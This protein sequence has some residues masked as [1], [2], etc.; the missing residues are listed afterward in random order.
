M[1]QTTA[2]CCSPAVVAETGP[3]LRETQSLCRAPNG[4]SYIV[5]KSPHQKTDE[6]FFLLSKRFYFA[7]SQSLSCEV[8]SW[9][10][11]FIFPSYLYMTNLNLCFGLNMATKEGVSVC[12]LFSSWLLPPRSVF[13]RSCVL[14]PGTWIVLHLGRKWLELLWKLISSCRA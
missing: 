5:W 13:Y 2:S 14:C 1:S 6:K 7:D 8:D 9:I 11:K 12:L 4:L 10:F 3:M